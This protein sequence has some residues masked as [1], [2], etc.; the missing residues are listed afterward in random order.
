ML[1]IDGMSLQD[2]IEE[3]R[4]Y[5]ALPDQNKMLIQIKHLLLETQEEKA[6]VQILRGSEK[7]TASEYF[8]V[9]IQL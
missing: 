3:Q 6:E 5:H 8:G 4:K 2:R 7:N 9:S 1:E